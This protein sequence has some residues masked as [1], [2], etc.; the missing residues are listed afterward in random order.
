MGIKGIKSTILHCDNMDVISNCTNIGIPLA[1]KNIDLSYH[2]VREH[3]VD[4]VYESRKIKAKQ[5]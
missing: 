4:N 2:F 1:K 3:M 5:N